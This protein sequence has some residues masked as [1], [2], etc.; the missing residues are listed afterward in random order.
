[1]IQS[2]SNQITTSINN[3]KSSDI[4]Y[5]FSTQL[6]GKEILIFLSKNHCF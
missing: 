3:V 4:A 2:R 1:M 5:V 6:F